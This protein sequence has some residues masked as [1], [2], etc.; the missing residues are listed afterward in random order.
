LLLSAASTIWAALAPWL[1]D[2]AL[3]DDSDD[4]SAYI[5][6]Q[7]AEAEC[8]DLVRVDVVWRRVVTCTHLRQIARVLRMLPACALASRLLHDA[9]GSPSD[10]I[11]SLMLLVRCCA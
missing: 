9:C 3:T 7:C 5:G 6:A 2:R 4:V 11:S 8:L 1:R 10:V